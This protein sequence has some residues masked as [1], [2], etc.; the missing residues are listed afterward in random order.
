[1]LTTLSN[2]QRAQLP[3][4]RDKWLEIGLS[5]QPADRKAAEAGMIEAYKAAGLEPPKQFLWLGSP[6]AGNLAATKLVKAAAKVKDMLEEVEAG[7]SVQFDKVVNAAI[8]DSHAAVDYWVWKA[9][10]ELIWHRADAQL[11]PIVMAARA[12]LSEMEPVSQQVMDPYGTEDVISKTG[13]ALGTSADPN[14]RR[15]ICSKTSAE[16]VDQLVVPIIAAILA[17]LRQFDKVRTEV[18]DDVCRDT[19]HATFEETDFGVRMDIDRVLKRRVKDE[20]QRQVLVAIR[21]GLQELAQNKSSQDTIRKAASKATWAVADTIS[22]ASYDEVNAMR[23]QV[24][25]EVARAISML[26]AD[27]IRGNKSVYSRFVNAAKRFYRDIQ[28]HEVRER[29]RLEVSL[30]TQHEDFD[31]SITACQLVISQLQDLAKT[32]FVAGDAITSLGHVVEDEQPVDSKTN[33]EVDRATIEVAATDWIW[34]TVK[35]ALQSLTAKAIVDGLQKRSLY[36]S[37]TDPAREAIVEE[38]TLNV[39]LDVSELSNDVATT[40]AIVSRVVID[41]MRDLAKTAYVPVDEARRD[42]REATA[43]AVDTGYWR[44]LSNDGRVWGAF[45]QTYVALRSQVMEALISL[46]GE[47]VR[48]QVVGDVHLA[49]NQHVPAQDQDVVFQDV[50]LQQTSFAIRDFLYDAIRWQLHELIAAEGDLSGLDIGASQSRAF[51][52]LTKATSHGVRNEV[53]AE[54]DNSLWDS[55]LRNAYLDVMDALREVSLPRGHIPITEVAPEDLVRVKWGTM[56]TFRYSPVGAALS[57][58]LR[59]CTADELADEFKNQVSRAG[60]GHHDAGWLSGYEFFKDECKIEAC[61]KLSGLMQVAKSS[62]WFWPFTNLCIMTERPNVL[63]R[64]AERRLH[65]ETGPAIAYPDNW[66]LY[67]WHG[68]RVPK[69]VVEAPETITAQEIEEETNAEVRRI[70]LERFGLE[71]YLTTTGDIEKIHSDDFGTL[72]RKEFEDDEPLVMVLV[73]NSTKEPDGSYKNY[74]LRVPPEME[75][76]KQAIAWTFGLE[77]HQYTPLIQT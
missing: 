72:Y 19:V 21:Q 24:G 26:V 63:H 30:E 46:A 65:C 56:M 3:V 33:R 17:D 55:L 52:G 20:V 76:A 57:A 71:R 36:A 48:Q 38:S 66:G 64:D 58:I 59:E 11:D 6:F 68:V 61:E 15:E 4:Y 35:A 16:V 22:G 5:T 2:A 50:V 73:V 41:A 42:L 53:D 12:A 13:R 39:R 14:V 9:V 10:Q 31:L 18:D 51:K 8:V 67:V 70:M 1:M 34:L 29:A 44:Q 60:Y 75:R 28:R 25:A 54:I 45:V 27:G 23:G 43:D 37:A 40:E 74:V 49:A 47:T 32:A 7:N 62:G 77:E 69:H